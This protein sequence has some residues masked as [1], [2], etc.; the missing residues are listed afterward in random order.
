[1]RGKLKQKGDKTMNLSPSINDV[2]T[3]PSATFWL[4]DAL[5]ALEKRDPVDA[6]ND[7]ALIM[8][9]VSAR[10]DALQDQ[11]AKGEHHE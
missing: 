10:L 3:D 2:L 9:I 5:R 1:M 11:Y 6:F 8:R 4:K 7:V